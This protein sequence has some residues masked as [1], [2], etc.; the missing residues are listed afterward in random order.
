MSRD[1][2][3]NIQEWFKIFI[4]KKGIIEFTTGEYEIF[5]PVRIKRYEKVW[6][7]IEPH[8][9]HTCGYLPLNE[10][11]VIQKENGFIVIAKVESH[12]V[13][14]FWYIK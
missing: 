1:L 7:H 12:L 9:H 14:F 8:D 2:F 5:V 13:K 4:S 10:F 3:K 6:F 11:D